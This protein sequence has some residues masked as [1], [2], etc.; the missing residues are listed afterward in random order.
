MATMILLARHSV[1][2]H[3]D[4]CFISVWK[5]TWASQQRWLE[6]IIWTKIQQLSHSTAVGKFLKNWKNR[7]IT[8]YE[9]ITL[10]LFVGFLSVTNPQGIAY[11]FRISRIISYRPRSCERQ[12]NTRHPLIWCF[13]RNLTNW[14]ENIQNF[15]WRASHWMPILTE[16]AL[17]T[18]WSQW[19]IKL[20]ILALSVLRVLKFEVVNRLPQS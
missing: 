15:I 6:S 4:H 16:A 17:P 1:V 7:Q 14:I 18:R 8:S 10:I 12:S 13:L 19:W 20:C 11:C 9:S 3:C 5:I 2:L